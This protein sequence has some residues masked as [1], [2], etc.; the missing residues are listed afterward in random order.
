MRPFRSCR[1]PD[2]LKVQIRNYLNSLD[3]FFNFNRADYNDVLRLI[4]HIKDN[5][6][7]MVNEDPPIKQPGDYCDMTPFTLIEQWLGKMQA[8]LDNPQGKKR[9]LGRPPKYTRKEIMQMQAT[10]NENIRNNIPPGE[11][12][13]RVATKFSVP[14]GKSPDGK[15]A[16]RIVKYHSEKQHIKQK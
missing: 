2:E 6:P 9:K 13:Q 4:G 12:W 10:Y 11:S 1:K 8:K 14:R 15:A 5:N 3:Y 7:T 16:Q